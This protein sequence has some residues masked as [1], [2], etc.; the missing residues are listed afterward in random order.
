MKSTLPTG[1]RRL[2]DLGTD[3]ETDSAALDQV[4]AGFDDTI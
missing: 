3:V 1:M 4:F 2:A